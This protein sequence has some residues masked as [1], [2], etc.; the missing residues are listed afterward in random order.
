MMSLDNYLKIG[1]SVLFI[2][3]SQ[4]FLFLIIAEALYP[5]YSI[6]E[7]FLSDLGATCHPG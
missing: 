2:G 7:Q 5:G 6:S 1:G 4:F 3:R